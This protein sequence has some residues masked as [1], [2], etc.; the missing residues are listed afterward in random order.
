MAISVFSNDTRA[1][2][3]NPGIAANTLPWRSAIAN[4]VTQTTLVSLSSA[5]MLESVI[6]E[7]SF[8]KE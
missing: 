8:V 7:N 2:F 5:H 4:I 1:R 6:V 3:D